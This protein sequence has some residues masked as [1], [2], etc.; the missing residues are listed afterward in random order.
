MCYLRLEARRR[1]YFNLFARFFYFSLLVL[2]ISLHSF[3]AFL[4]GS[5]AYSLTHSLTYSRTHLLACSLTHLLTCYL[6]TIIIIIY[7]ILIS[8][9]CA[10]VHTC[11]EH[12]KTRHKNRATKK[13]PYNVAVKNL[14]K[15]KSQ[16]YPYARRLPRLMSRLCAV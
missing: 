16:S 2:S 13:P 1:S 10:H 8:F 5:L 11:E 3:F 15:Y 6:M 4:T 14:L 7:N 12:G 9:V